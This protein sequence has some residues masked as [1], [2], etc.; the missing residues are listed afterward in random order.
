MGCLQYL[1]PVVWNVAGARLQ[2]ASC[3]CAPCLISSCK[4][5]GSHHCIIHI[6]TQTSPCSLLMSHRTDSLL[7]G[8][9]HTGPH[10]L[11][12]PSSKCSHV[13][14]RL[15]R[16]LLK[17]SVRLCFQNALYDN[18]LPTAEPHFARLS[19]KPSSFSTLQSPQPSSNFPHVEM[20]LGFGRPSSILDFGRETNPTRLC[21]KPHFW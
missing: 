5:F 11:G 4:F 15:G 18:V 14:C 7:A 3:R 16:R 13:H 8:V 2:V 6:Q 1:P 10:S 9:L 21:L 20:F 19:R 17:F 12:N